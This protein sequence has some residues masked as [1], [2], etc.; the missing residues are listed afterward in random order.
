MFGFGKDKDKENCV[1]NNSYTERSVEENEEEN[2]ENEEDDREDWQIFIEKVY[3]KL[4]T[5]NY[6]RL[7][8]IGDAILLNVFK[9]REQ[10]FKQDI[11]IN[12][13]YD[14]DDED[15]TVD[16]NINGHEVFTNSYEQGYYED[17]GELMEDVEELYKN[18]LFFTED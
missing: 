8:L 12:V 9:V 18:I 5:H 14:E 2:E 10:D 6:K 3:E 17:D 13:Y 15:I 16:V 4:S 7:L 11:F 1:K